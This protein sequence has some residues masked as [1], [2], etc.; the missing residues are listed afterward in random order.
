MSLKDKQKWDDK[1]LNTPT[2]LEKRIPCQ[3]LIKFS[4]N[5]DAKKA[6]DFACGN[7]R[8]AIHLAKLGYIVDAFDISAIP[9]EDL[10]KQNIQ[11]IHTKRIDLENF[12]TDKRYDLII[13]CNYL[14]RDAIKVLSECLNKDGIFIIETYMEHESNEKPSSNPDFLL[15]PN[16][17]QKFFDQRFEIIDYDEFD[18]EKHELYRMKKQSIV[19]RKL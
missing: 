19:V 3:K 6:L 4:Q 14:D 13:K 11:N 7:G 5:V 12:T 2:L 16:E 10:N 17:L 1:Y 8:N 18:N 9:L 15:K